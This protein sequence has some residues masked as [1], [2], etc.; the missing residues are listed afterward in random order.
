MKIRLEAE[1]RGRVV[2]ARDA[3]VAAEKEKEEEAVG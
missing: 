2:A 3:K 1:A